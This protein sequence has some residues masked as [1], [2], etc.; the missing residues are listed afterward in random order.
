MTVHALESWVT[1]LRMAHRSLK[2]RRVA[3]GDPGD[4][5]ASQP[6]SA[7]SSRCTSPSSA[8][9]GKH[10]QTRDTTWRRWKPSTRAKSSAFARASTKTGAVLRQNADARRFVVDQSGSTT[11]AM[12]RP[13]SSTSMLQPSTPTASTSPVAAVDQHGTAADRTVHTGPYREA[14]SESL[15]TRAGTAA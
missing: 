15:E 10:P 7:Y 3:T 14:L 12:Q 5:Q 8:I 4:R 2:Q 1:S 6:L 11:R 9:P 13:P